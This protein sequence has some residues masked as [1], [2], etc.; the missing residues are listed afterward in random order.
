MYKKCTQLAI[1]NILKKKANDM[2]A[3][4]LS[5]EYMIFELEKI[6]NNNVIAKNF[7]HDDIELVKYKSLKFLKKIKDEYMLVKN[8]RINGFS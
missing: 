1:D 3:S 2:A 4:G 8:I 5:S 7:H 6:I